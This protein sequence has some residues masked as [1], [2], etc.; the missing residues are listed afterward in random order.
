MEDGTVSRICKYCLLT[1]V[2]KKTTTNI[3]SRRIAI[4][5]CNVKKEDKATPLGWKTKKD[6]VGIHFGRFFFTSSSG[7]PAF[8][9]FCF[10]RREKECGAESTFSFGKK[11]WS[12]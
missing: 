7:H 5:N 12:K 9:Q 8:L 2:K 3:G 10:V 11:I 1:K 4:C 6:K